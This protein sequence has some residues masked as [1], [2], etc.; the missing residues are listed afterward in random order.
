MKVMKA[1]TINDNRYKPVLATIE[2]HAII[3]PPDAKVEPVIEEYVTRT[4][5]F[6]EYLHFDNNGTLDGFMDHKNNMYVLDNEY[7]TRKSI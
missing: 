3:L 4:N 1:R 6:V 7:D 2:N 5:Y